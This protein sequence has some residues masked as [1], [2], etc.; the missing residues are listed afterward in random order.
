MGEYLKKVIE[1][2]EVE[3]E[4]EPIPIDPLAEKITPRMLEILSL[5]IDDPILCEPC[6]RWLHSKRAQI[7]SSKLAALY[8]PEEIEALRQEMQEAS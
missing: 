4:S 7:A 2:A 1:A 6:L 3:L 8:T 5:L